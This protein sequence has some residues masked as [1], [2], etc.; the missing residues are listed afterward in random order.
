MSRNGAWE[1]SRKGTGERDGETVEVLK[2]TKHVGQSVERAV[3]ALLRM[4]THDATAL[5]HVTDLKT[6]MA[7]IRQ[8]KAELMAAVLSTLEVGGLS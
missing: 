6:L 7:E 4:A 2:D 1:V 8:A 5:D 3:S